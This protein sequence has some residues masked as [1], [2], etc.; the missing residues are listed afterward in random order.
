M[1]GSVQAFSKVFC[2][3]TVGLVGI[4]ALGACTS[5]GTSPPSTPPPT[6]TATHATSATAVSGPPCD[7]TAIAKAVPSGSTVVAFKCANGY[8]AASLAPEAWPIMQAEGNMWV[9][10]KN[11]CSV[12][13]SV[14]AATVAKICGQ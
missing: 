3:A 11:T 13:G 7:K 14:P 2:A 4:A 9:I 6:P 10:T 12:P 5:S 1:A 8:A